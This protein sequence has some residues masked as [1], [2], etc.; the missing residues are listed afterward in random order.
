MNLFR[1]FHSLMILGSLGMW[2]AS[3]LSGYASDDTQPPPTPEQTAFF[4]KSIRPLLIE[5]CFACHSDKMQM[6]GL[7]LDTRAFILKGNDHGSSLNM[8]HPELSSVI[9]VIHYDGAVKMPPVGKLKPLEIAALTEWVQI[10]APWPADKAAPTPSGT[11]PMIITDAQRAFWSFKPVRKPAIPKVK[12]KAWVKSG[13]DSFILSKLE[14]K[15][16][17][18][19]PPDDRRSLIR[20]AY[21]DL[22]GLPPTPLEVQAFLVDKSPNAFAKVVDHLLASSH[23][24]EQWGRHWLDVARYADSNGLDENLAFGNAY[25]YRDYVIDA[26]NKDKPYNQFICEQLAGDLI[27]AANDAERNEHLTATGFLSMGPKVLAEQDKPKMVMDIVDEQIEVS[28]K[29]FMGLTIACARC[30]NHKFD[31]FPTKDYYALAG[32][33]KSTKTM[34]D[35]GFVSRVNE[36]DL[37]TTELKSQ[38][39]A[40]N[41]KLKILQAAYKVITDKGNAELIDLEKRDFEKYLTVGWELAHQPIIKSVAETKLKTDDGRILIEAENFNRG[42]VVKN[43]DTYGKGIGVIN[44]SGAHGYA[45]WDI[46]IPNT[47][48]Y[49]IELRY[50]SAEKRPVRILANGK[51]LQRD[52]ASQS[53]GSFNPDGQKWEAQ[54]V[55]LLNA[56]KNT[57]RIEVD[58]NFP[59]IDKILFIPY[60][61]IAGSGAKIPLNAVQLSETAGVNSAIAL[62]SAEII[63]GAGDIKAARTILAD[64]KKGLLSIPDKAE[65][66]YTAAEQALATSADAAVKGEEA[67]APKVPKTLAVEEGEIQDVKVHIRGSTLTLGE[68]A[69]RTFLAVLGGDKVPPV[70]SKHSGRLEFAKW[71]TRPEH[72]LTSRVEV[73]R[74]WQT[75]FGMG[76]V[77]TPDNWGLLGDRPQQPEL[78]DWLAATFI[79]DGWSLKKMHRRIM[80]SSAYQMSCAE[81]PKAMLADPDNRLIWRMNRI[82]LDAEPFRDAILT[83]AGQLDQKMGGSLMSTGDND[84]VTNDQS[85]NAGQYTSPRRSVYLPVIR[86]ALF[87]MFQAFDFGDPSAPHAMRTS[88]TVAPQALY[89]MNSPFIL[90]ESKN[91]A[92]E[93]IVSA[94]DDTERIKHGYLRALSRP[95]T[96][97]EFERTA[98]YLNRYQTQLIPMEKDA[99]KRRAMAWESLCQI[100]FA[101]NEFIY[102]N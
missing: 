35:L 9:K 85:G 101:S 63:K 37:M 38:V 99:E 28:S 72:P 14:A 74:I 4:E 57:L 61:A 41:E 26:I 84:Y 40:H 64:S 82:R 16:L 90:E 51:I 71:L 47:D 86:N 15:A 89:V 21:F 53:T 6:G 102:L 70:D 3:I 56:G 91:F 19:A 34:S 100:I 98:A 29:A 46:S 5:K 50:A 97:K 2:S 20:R 32:I 76:I 11:A 54:T 39:D 25:R 44:S 1:S 49:Q 48:G 80:L 8:K 31:P 83:V 18:P 75:H 66:Y 96:I 58:G 55:T 92:K 42:T 62:R 60:S 68:V 88:T 10:G 81:D 65:Q 36:R 87:E 22:I 77:R 95:P 27:P 24:G 17:K 67:A 23:Y 69:P 73:N 33:F 45:E 43:F 13:I 12:N 30:H 59:H 78:L 52:A 7:R 79:E 93:L 94:S